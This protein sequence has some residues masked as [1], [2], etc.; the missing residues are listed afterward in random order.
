[1]LIYCFCSV[2]FDREMDYCQTWGGC[3]FWRVHWNR[4]QGV[5]CCYFIFCNGFSWWYLKTLQSS[6]FCGDC[7]LHNLSFLSIF[8]SMVGF[9]DLL[10]HW[11]TSKTSF[12]F[13]FFVSLQATLWYWWS[14]RTTQMKVLISWLSTIYYWCC[15]WIDALFLIFWLA[16]VS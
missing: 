8:V 2:D 3:S 16:T 15:F 11:R 14:L 6:C 13:L 1:M 7:C 12:I 4:N 10:G 9:C 5:I